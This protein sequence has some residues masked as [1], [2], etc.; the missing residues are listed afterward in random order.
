MTEPYAFGNISTALSRQRAKKVA[1]FGKEIKF[2]A[3]LIHLPG[4]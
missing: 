4:L 3:H 1:K 2:D